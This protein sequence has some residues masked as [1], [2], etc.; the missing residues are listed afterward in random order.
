MAIN[1]WKKYREKSNSIAWWNEKEQEGISI[2]QFINNKKRE[3]SFVSEGKTIK[4]FKTKQQ[5]L[6]YAKH[7]MRNN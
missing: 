7:Y 2:V 6:A 4:E 1:D 5:A 3:W